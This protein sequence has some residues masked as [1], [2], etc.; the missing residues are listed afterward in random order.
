MNTPMD[1]LHVGRPLPA[2]QTSRASER[3]WR[4]VPALRLDRAGTPSPS[5]EGRVGM[6]FPAGCENVSMG[7]FVT[8]RKTIP[9]PVLPLKG[10]ALHGLR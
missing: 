1:Q 10:R 9:T 3:R 4:T 2:K 8:S 5:R 6:V 7:A